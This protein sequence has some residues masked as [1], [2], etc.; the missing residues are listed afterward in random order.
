MM[1]LLFCALAVGCGIDRDFSELFNE[2]SCGG[3]RFLAA[4]KRVGGE[5][6]TF[7]Q[8]A[9][10][11]IADDEVTPQPSG[12][13]INRSQPSFRGMLRTQSRRWRIGGDRHPG[14]RQ[15]PFKLHFH[16]SVV[17]GST[18]PLESSR[19]PGGVDLFGRR[20]MSGLPGQRGKNLVVEGTV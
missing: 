7:A 11:R 13:L 20:L 16:L 9:C 5:T 4:G 10:R 12:S 17:R 19:A 2:C 8:R 6:G 3:E 14:S 18:R 1:S 15:Y